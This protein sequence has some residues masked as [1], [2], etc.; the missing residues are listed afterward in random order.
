MWT[1]ASEKTMNTIELQ[2]S[3]ID[4]HINPKCISGVCSASGRF[5]NDDGYVNDYKGHQNRY[6]FTF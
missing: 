5:L 1:N 4:L 2:K 3:P 6:D